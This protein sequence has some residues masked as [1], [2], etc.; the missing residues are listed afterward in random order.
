MTLEEFHK[1]LKMA[2]KYNIEIVNAYLDSIES[3]TL[4]KL[5]KA[6]ISFLVEEGEV[7]LEN[8]NW[9]RLIKKKDYLSS[10]K[11]FDESRIHPN[12][13]VRWDSKNEMAAHAAYDTFFRDIKS[14]EVEIIY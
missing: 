5:A 9:F 8:G 13:I 12:A 2:R 4:K 6:N 11:N 7:V 14:S 1:V 3:K 10:V